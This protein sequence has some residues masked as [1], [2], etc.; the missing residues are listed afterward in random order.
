VGAGVS[1]LH[2]ALKIPVAT[3]LVLR[4]QVFIDFKLRK[5]RNNQVSPPV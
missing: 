4:S 5:N 3:L 2:S 1:C